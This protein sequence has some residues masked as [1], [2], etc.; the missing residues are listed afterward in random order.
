[1]KVV[2][3]PLSELHSPERN[4]RLHT[5]KQ[6]KEFRRSVEMFGQIRPI[7]VD[8]GGMILAG[9]GLFE[10]I[11]DNLR[12]KTPGPRYCHFPKRDDYGAGYFSG[13]LSE[14]LTYNEKNARHPWQWEKIPGHERNE[15]LDCRN[16]AMAAFEVLPK[17]LDAIDRQIQAARGKAV[18]PPT[19]KAVAPAPAVRRSRVR[20]TSRMEEW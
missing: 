9:N 7:V 3:K 20:K 17:N 1:M 10:A 2:K 8:E 16:Y 18:G 15:A 19:D 5:D 6:L 13:L 12:V 11:M 4:V 14:R